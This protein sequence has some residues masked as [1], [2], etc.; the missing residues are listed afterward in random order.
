M[1][2]AEI[3][4]HL[5]QMHYDQIMSLAQPMGETQLRFVLSADCKDYRRLRTSPLD[6]A[7]RSPSS[8]TACILLDATE[9]Q[10]NLTAQLAQNLRNLSNLRT[11][12]RIAK[13]RCPV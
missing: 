2:N 8:L 1:R 9:L 12:N 5:K 10:P 7:R 6:R 4:L 11:T 13:G 3:L